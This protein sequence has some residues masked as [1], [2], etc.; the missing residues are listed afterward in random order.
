MPKW[1][2]LCLRIAIAAIIGTFLLRSAGRIYN[3]AGAW[4]LGAAMEI[5][6]IALVFGAVLFL[7]IGIPL[8]QQLGE[9]TTH[10]FMPT[11][12][13]F[14][15]VPQ[16][17]V[18]EARVKE[19]KY[20]EAVEEYRKVIVE[21]PDDVYPH[22]R[23][24]ELAVEHMHDLKLAETEL[25]AGQAKAV[26]EDA[27]ALIA[28]KL[29]DLYQHQFHDPQ[30]GLDVLLGVHGKLTN[31]KHVKRTGE[32][33]ESMQQSVESNQLP[34]SPKNIQLRK[35]RYRMHDDPSQRS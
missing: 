12:E 9:K 27:V 19:G 24:S 8:L 7:L 1:L 2:S 21:H 11:D 20:Q 23:I 30:R 6:G 26:Q 10:L 25:L 31:A 28:H 4:D 15:V 35:S 13:N 14:P 34:Q 32:R 33:I 29:A 5:L 16:Y 22:I 18:A 17:S 3:N